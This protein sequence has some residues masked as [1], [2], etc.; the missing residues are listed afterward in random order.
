MNFDPAGE[1]AESAAAFESEMRRRPPSHC[2]LAPDDPGIGV[3]LHVSKLTN[4]LPV[5]RRI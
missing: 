2:G 4:S 1:A 5:R 3:V